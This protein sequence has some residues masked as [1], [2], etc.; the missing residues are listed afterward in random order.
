MM[1]PATARLAAAYRDT[2]YVAHGVVIRVGRRSS[3]AER[4][5]ARHGARTGVFVTA[6]NPLGHGCARAWNVRAMRRLRTILRAARVAFVDGA[7]CGRDGV[8]PAEP[9][10]FVVGLRARAALALGRRLRQNAVVLVRPGQPAE[11]VALR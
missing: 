10:V 3:G 9:S 5:L 4:L 8:W 6:C 2:D 7:G 11:L 1:F